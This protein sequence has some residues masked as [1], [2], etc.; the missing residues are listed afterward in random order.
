MRKEGSSEE[1]YNYDHSVVEKCIQSF[2]NELNKARAIRGALLTVPAGVSQ[3][4]KNR[5][6]E[7]RAKVMIDS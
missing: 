6:A 5:M 1:R 4:V 3:G 2:A 7:L